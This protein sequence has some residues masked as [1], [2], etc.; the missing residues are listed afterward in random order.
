MK[1]DKI[2]L[3]NEVR[4]LSNS[5]V[6]LPKGICFSLDKKTL[7]VSL[8]TKSVTINLQNNNAAFEGWILI[9]KNWIDSIDKVKLAWEIPE[10]KFKNLIEAQHYQ[11]FLYR[12]TKFNK[13]YSWFE[14]EDKNKISIKSLRT[15]NNDND[16]IL[17]IPNNRKLKPNKESKELN[18]LSESELEKYIFQNEP[19]LNRFK[20]TFELELANY[21]L[22]I[23]LF[24]G[25]VT[26]D[27]RI[28]PGGKSAID[29]YGI[30]NKNQFCLFELKT[31][32]NKKVGAISEMLFYAWMIY[33]V[34][35]KLFKFELTN[36]EELK[37][38]LE[39]KGMNCYL[40]APETHPLIDTRL[41]Q[42]MS[43]NNYG[44]NYLKSKINED[45]S[46]TIKE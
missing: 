28:F 13:C 36:T 20:E 26:K 11:R 25:K 16:L 41:M 9:L 44:I 42:L 40:L 5:N 30:N 24:N 29:I 21:Q 19:T 12:V 2:E 32:R 17:N 39:T 37:K 15:E 31:A 35:M 23:G 1:I 43:K 8:D 18:K 6:R 7:S 46:F 27:C 4:K 34:Q 14:I 38:I 45:W 3:E 22:P 33:D 10:D